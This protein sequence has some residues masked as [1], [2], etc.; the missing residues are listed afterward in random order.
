MYD[1]SGKLIRKIHRTY[2]PIPFT[3]KD[4]EEYYK[5]FEN[6]PNPMFLKIVKKIDLPKI[7]TV[8]NR[9]IVDSRGNLW[10]ETNEKK[11]ENEID[12]VAYDVFN[13]DGYYD[14]KI[15][16]DHSPDLFAKGKMYRMEA[17]EETGYL[18]L[19]RYRVIW[20]D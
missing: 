12:Y 11:K 4:A 8:A 14:S 17:D 5:D 3:D 18:F 6:A 16:L 9:M 15:W 13:K 19:K 20:A 10:M 7:K 1:K 2:E